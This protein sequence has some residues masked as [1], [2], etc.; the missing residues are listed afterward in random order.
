MLRYYHVHL[1][2]TAGAPALRGKGARRRV[3]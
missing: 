2:G 1:Y 3:T